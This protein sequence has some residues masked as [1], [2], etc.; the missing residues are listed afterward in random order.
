MKWMLRHGNE[1]AIFAPVFFCLTFIN[2]RVKLFFTKDWFNGTLEKN[3]YLLTAF[4]YTNNEQSRLLQ[5]YIP[6]AFHRIFGMTIEHAYILQRFTFI[7]LAF[8][9]FHFYLRKWFSALESFAGVAFL[10]AIMPLA[11][12]NHL[13]ESAPL[14]LLTF[15][16]GLWAT[17]EKAQIAFAI[18][19]FV[20]TI[21]NET[22]LILPLAYFAFHCR[23]WSFR[24]CLRTGLQ[25]LAVSAP[26]IC[27]FL[28]IRYLTRSNEHL[29]NL[30]LL[31]E[32]MERMGRDFLLSPFEFHTAFYLYIFF[33][34]GVF[35]IYPFLQWKKQDDFLRRASIIIPP[36]I[37][38]HFL[39]GVIAEVR[40][41]VPLAYLLIPMSFLELRRMIDSSLHAGQDA[42][43]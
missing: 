9:L 27:T 39:T 17:R 10:S 43:G 3:H 25:T 40:Q 8:M 4:D 12:F 33:I 15:L 11:Y 37:I 29:G 32:N 41:M 23:E 16:L 1:W 24:A 34:F 18:I 30:F 28:F 6:E 22:M 14:L 36:F 19:L 35:W 5:F 20:G 7:F 26:A 42:L 2:L 13:Q 31:S 21:N 38:I